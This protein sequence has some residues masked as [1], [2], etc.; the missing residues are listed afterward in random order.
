MAE[1]SL[2]AVRTLHRRE[3]MPGRKA[4]RNPYVR[5]AAPAD[6]EA[7]PPVPIADTIDLDG[8]TPCTQ[9]QMTPAIKSISF[10]RDSL[11]NWGKPIEILTK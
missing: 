9:L 1:H 6:R 7:S 11:F 10:R 5:G 8:S 2:I 3:R 4:A